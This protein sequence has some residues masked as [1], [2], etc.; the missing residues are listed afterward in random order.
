MSAFF[1]CSVA[2]FAA[3]VNAAHR[4]IREYLDAFDAHTKAISKAFEG[5]DK[6]SEAR[7]RDLE[8]LVDRL[9]SRWEEIKRESARLDSRA[10][11]AVKGIRQE[12]AERGEEADSI[13]ELAAE[14]QLP[15]AERSQ[16]EGVHPMPPSVA[17]NEQIADWRSV[18]RTHMR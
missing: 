15:D 9:P 4:L 14:L 13:E 3:T 16:P 6:T 5:D 12:L 17:V 18:L 11:Y 8:D 2:L 7:F 10:R 1:V